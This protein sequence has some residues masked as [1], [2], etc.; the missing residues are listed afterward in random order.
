MA[1]VDTAILF[2]DN[3]AD[4]SVVTS[5]AI[6]MPIGRT[7]L[8]IFVA[9]TDADLDITVQVQDP[10]SAWHTVSTG[11]TVL[12]GTCDGLVVLSNPGRV[13]V[14]VTPSAGSSSAIIWARA[15]GGK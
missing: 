1:G 9:P 15:M 8:T 4:T 11:T 10:T 14:L 7:G 6:T 3:F 12:D 5:D 13:R 2:N